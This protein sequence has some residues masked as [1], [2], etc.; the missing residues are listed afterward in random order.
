[1]TYETIPI[2]HS[3]PTEK[4][5]TEHLVIGQQYFDT[6]LGMPIFWN[7]TKWIISASDVDEKLKDY[8]RIDKLFTTDI[9]RAPEFAG[10]I[11]IANDALYVAESTASTN[12]WRM[13]TLQPNDTL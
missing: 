3:G 5:P 12:S 1:M 11:A 9:S 4:R 8:I 10:Q 13:A 2:I 6:T 7:G